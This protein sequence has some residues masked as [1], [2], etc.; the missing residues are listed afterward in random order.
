MR[1][2]SSSSDQ[3]LHR[4]I[5]TPSCRIPLVYIYIH[6]Y[7]YI[8]IY[9]YIYIYIYIY[10]FVIFSYVHRTVKCDLCPSSLVVYIYIYIYIYI[11]NINTT[12]IVK[13][14]FFFSRI[15]LW[16]KMPISFCDPYIF[17]TPISTG[18][19]CI[20]IYICI[21]IKRGNERERERGGMISPFWM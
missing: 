3:V 10:M 2:I 9:M 7:L 6:I 14:K 11:Y 4:K 8:Y 13:K 19:R 17:V 18:V 16:S 5:L 20:Y 21:Y 15:W 12:I 1:W